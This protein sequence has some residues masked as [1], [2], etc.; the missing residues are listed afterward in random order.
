MLNGYRLRLIRK[1]NGFTQEQLGSLLGVSKSEISCYENG[2]RVPPLETIV[3]LTRIFGVSTDYL[4]N[5]DY[6]TKIKRKTGKAKY[7]SLTKEELVFIKELRKNPII[8]NILLEDPQRGA[9]LIK[10]EIG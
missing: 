10:K 2:V 4:L 5:V 1:Q 6:L 3:N 8:Y 9:N 7:V